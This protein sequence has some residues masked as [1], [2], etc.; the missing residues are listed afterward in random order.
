M[1]NNAIS[2]KRQN[3]ILEQ[4]YTKEEVNVKEL[5]SEFNVTPI[6]IRRDLDTLSEKGLIDRVHGGAIMTKKLRDEALFTEK[7]HRNIDE[8]TKIGEIAA[9]LIKEDDTV[10]LNS[11]S[12]TLEI[13]KNLKGK[14]VRVITNNAAAIN[15]ERDAQ[16]ELFLVGG[17]YR[18]ASQSLIGDMAQETLSQVY[19][20]CTILGVNGISKQFGLTSNVQQETSINRIMVERCHGSVI[21]VADSSK[22][23]IV[24]NF[25][26]ASIDRVSVLIT[27]DKINSDQI[28]EFE[29]LGIKVITTKEQ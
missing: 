13:I 19:S 6:T 3:R 28:S 18:E 9:S 1:R 26:T 10:F 20:S 7:G 12:T 23:G 16:V 25:S 22:I 4:L 27:D 21:V 8:K 24:S 29:Q 17:E 2:Q 14:H 11:G 5:S 15:V